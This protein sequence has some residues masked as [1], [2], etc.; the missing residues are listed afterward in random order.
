M[1]D[2]RGGSHKDIELTASAGE[3]KKGLWDDAE[4]QADDEREECDGDGD[5]RMKPVVRGAKKR[6]RSGVGEELV[7]KRRI[8]RG[9]FPLPRRNKVVGDQSACSLRMPDPDVRL[10]SNVLQV[11]RLCTGIS[12]STQAKAALR[13]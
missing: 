1:D 5:R 12:T 9:R 6:C 3:G 7:P 13:R 8:P 2:P 10:P 11:I 4:M